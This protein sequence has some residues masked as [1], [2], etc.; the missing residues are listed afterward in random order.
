MAEK[1]GRLCAGP[2]KAPVNWAIRCHP[3]MYLR[4][5]N[6]EIIDAECGFDQ[7]KGSPCVVIESSGG[8]SPARGVKR[9]NPDYNE[10][11][12]LLFHRLAKA[13]VEITL[14]VL[15]SSKVSGLPVEER[16]AGLTRPYPIDLN[17]VDIEDFRKMLQREI[18]RMHRDPNA[19]QGGNAQ[20]RIRICLNK[21]VDPDRLIYKTEGSTDPAE[22]NFGPGLSETE[23]TYLRSSRIGQGQFRKDLIS[24]YGRRCPITG[25]EQDQLLIASHIKPWKVC[26]NAE[27][28]DSSNGILLSALVD[29]LFDKGL[30][31][32][33][34]EGAL[35][36]SPSLSTGD[37]AKCGIENWQRLQLTSRSKLYMAYH[38]AVEF[39]ST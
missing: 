18:A 19:K 23:R 36:F 2:C 3:P 14:V 7:F 28:L 30:V 5:D 24:K 20:K 29:R 39:K 10:L 13:D 11:L 1:L 17:S 32:F 8:A 15:D 31:T 34:E 33:S 22:E 37:R 26:T 12:T 9:R 25:I 27:R 6:N 35:I 38:R 21:S 16:V 4:D